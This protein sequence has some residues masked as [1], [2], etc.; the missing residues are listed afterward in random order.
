MLT[1]R[2]YEVSPE[3]SR[4][5]S[6]E[7]ESEEPHDDGVHRLVGELGVD[8]AHLGEVGRLGGP[9]GS[10]PQ[11][12]KNA[13]RDERVEAWIEL[14]ADVRRV[15]HHGEAQSPLDGQPFDD[16]RRHEDTGEYEGRVDGGQRH[17]A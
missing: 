9:H 4:L 16:E 15:A 14:R 1:Q 5:P 10:R 7:E 2:R 17:G 3:L 6:Q 8:A 13:C 12:E 11:A